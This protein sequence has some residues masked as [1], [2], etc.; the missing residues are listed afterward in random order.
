MVF[1]MISAETVILRR[2]PRKPG[3]SAL[4]LPLRD[5][6]LE[7][8]CKKKGEGKNTKNGNKNL[9]WAFV[10]A[11]NSSPNAARPQAKELRSIA[12]RARRS[13]SAIK[14]LAHKAGAGVRTTCGGSRSL[15]DV[16]WCFGQ[17]SGE[18][19]ASQESGLA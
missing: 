11:V 3:T 17:R 15:F 7:S 2:S 8:K 18:G 14:A 19:R 5:S 13:C 12:R 16:H 10:E 9:A 6:S 4:D 1:I